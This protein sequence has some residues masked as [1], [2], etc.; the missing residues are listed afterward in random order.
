MKKETV[1]NQ[2]SKLDAFREAELEWYKDKGIKSMHLWGYI[3]DEEYELARKFLYDLTDCEG[4]DLRTMINI[5][6]KL[7]EEIERLPMSEKIF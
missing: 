3:S 7:K 5:V 1:Y 2:L 6:T 4:I